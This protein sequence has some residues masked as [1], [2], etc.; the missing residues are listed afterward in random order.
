[1]AALYRV[2]C[3]ACDEPF[4]ARRRDAAYCSG[5]CQKRAKR[6]HLASAM[7]ERDLGHF[8]AAPVPIAV[9]SYVLYRG[10]LDRPEVLPVTRAGE[11]TG[12]PFAGC[13]IG[14][15]LRTAAREGWL[16]CKFRPN[17]WYSAEWRPERRSIALCGPLGL[18]LIE[19]T[20][21]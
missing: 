18:P 14:E 2:P 17:G 5:T 8:L 1:M 12:G 16:A 20:T 15:M 7:P 4:K 3:V 21:P 19:R 9:G 11:I 13:T 6:G 10:Q